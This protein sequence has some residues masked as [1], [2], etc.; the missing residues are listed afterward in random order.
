MTDTPA[1]VRGRS[2]W[3]QVRAATIVAAPAKDGFVSNDDTLAEEQ[4]TTAEPTVRAP[5]PPPRGLII[6]R[7][8]AIV[9]VL[10]LVG[11]LGFLIGWFATPDDSGSSSSAASQGPRRAGSRG[12]TPGPS[13]TTPPPASTDPSAAALR[14]LGLRPGDLTSSVSLVLIPRGNSV[15][16]APTL[17][18]CN[19]TY[20]SESQRKAR[21]QVA[22]LDDQGNVALSTESVLYSNAAATE[23]AFTELESAA[24]NC[25]NSPVTSPVG[26][27]AVTTQFNPAPDGSWPQVAGVDR[28]AYD[29]VTT[30]DTGQPDTLGCGVPP[31]RAGADGHLLPATRLRAGCDRGADHDPRNRQRLRRAHESTAGLGR[32]LTGRV[33]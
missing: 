24:A 3:S 13:T 26:E 23:Q 4:P 21:L 5:R 33:R 29:F 19:A 11:G 2:G 10:L 16:G 15:S 1:P 9:V 7:W 20:P 27:P 30:D 12:T 31:P 22:G 32:E 17:D 25:P 6:P 14:D 18:L 8:L 28:L